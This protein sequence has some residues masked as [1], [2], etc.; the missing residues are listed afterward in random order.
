MRP[1]G[2]VAFIAG[3]NNGIGLE[4]ARRFITEVAKVTINRRGQETVREAVLSAL[5]LASI[6]DSM[7]DEVLLGSF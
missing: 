3:G 7:K 5:A 2:K 1:S 6:A 4:T